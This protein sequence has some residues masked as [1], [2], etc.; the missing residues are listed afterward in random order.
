MAPG[1]SQ[2]TFDEM[3][4][5]ARAKA[6]ADLDE[7]AAMVPAA[8]TTRTMC[9]DADPGDAINGE[10]STGAYDLVVVG[11][12]G[13]SDVASI[14]LG[15]VSHRVIHQSHV[16]V[17]VVHVAETVQAANGHTRTGT[18]RPVPTD[19]HSGY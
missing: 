6:Q 7:A 19:S 11:S 2:A 12:R 9:V 13:R 10:L 14:V 3:A 1:V 5:T 17:L 8:V 16:P 18:E 15:S 4:E